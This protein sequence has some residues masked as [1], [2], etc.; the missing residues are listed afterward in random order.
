MSKQLL[1]AVQTRGYAD[2]PPKQIKGAFLGKKN[3][4]VCPEEEF[5]AL[6]S[7]TGS[8]GRECSL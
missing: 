4:D 7:G 6:V 3:K 5:Y 8:D 2:A 1:V